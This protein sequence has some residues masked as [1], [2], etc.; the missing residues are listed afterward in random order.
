M[1][2]TPLFLFTRVASYL[3]VFRHLHLR[4]GVHDLVNHDHRGNFY[5]YSCIA[6][7]A[8]VVHLPAL[9]KYLSIK[10][11]CR[12]SVSCLVNVSDIYQYQRPAYCR[13]PTFTVS[14]VI[15][16]SA[17]SPVNTSLSFT[18]FD[19]A[20][21]SAKSRF[22]VLICSSVWCPI[23]PVIGLCIFV[24]AIFVDVIILLCRVRWIFGSIVSLTPFFHFHLALG[25]LMFVPRRFSLAVTGD[26]PLS[27]PGPVFLEGESAA[28]PI[29]IA[30][31]MPFSSIF[32]LRCQTILVR[33][34]PCFNTK[35]VWPR[36]SIS[37][38]TCQFNGL[39]LALGKLRLVQT[40]QH[41][42][43]CVVSDRR[44]V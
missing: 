15:R 30:F 4:G 31:G 27:I 11:A 40:E 20:M 23:M 44:S 43:P 21:G 28:R 13:L 10:W 36:S 42:H 2:F 29:D 3:Q 19:R 24:L 14:P 9:F 18:L 25:L 26:L 32:S 12:C 39:H 34:T 38:S 16:F 33:Y 17:Y 5:C 37:I 6:L 1:S 22:R 41:N 7:F 35:A 8:V